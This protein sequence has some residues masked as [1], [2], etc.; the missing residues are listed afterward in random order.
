ML[1]EIELLSLLSCQAHQ[2]RLVQTTLGSCREHHRE[3]K[4]LLQTP[5]CSYMHSKR[6][7]PLVI[8]PFLQECLF[9]AE[10]AEVNT[11]GEKVLFL[12]KL[13]VCLAHRN[14]NYYLK[15]KE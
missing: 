11:K 4:P 5:G 12:R 15:I 1:L 9:N 14:C 6:K 10:T 3:V 8:P 7:T 2:Y 13:K